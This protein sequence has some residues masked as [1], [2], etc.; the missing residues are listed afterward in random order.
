[1]GG[2]KKKP[3]SSASKKEEAGPQVAEV[4]DEKKGK[5]EK[6]TKGPQQ[7]VKISVILN[8]GQ[9][10]KALADLKAV[11]PQALARN[12]GVKISVANA[13]LKSLESKGTVVCVGGY[14]GHRV[15]ALA[16]Q[17]KE[18]V[19]ETKKEEL[20]ETAQQTAN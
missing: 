11:T 19:Q 15:Y 7:K 5:K 9:G 18:F 14:S 20:G 1:M 10:M 17:T 2:V 16:E 4:K 13:F 8:E 12:T 6:G 3:L